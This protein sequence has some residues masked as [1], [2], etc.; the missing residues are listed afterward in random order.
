[1]TKSQDNLVWQ[2]AKQEKV[3]YEYLRN[4]VESKPPQEMIGEFR[5]LFLELRHNNTEVRQTLENIV[6]SK[7]KEYM[8]LQILNYCCHILINYWSQKAETYPY[9]WELLELFNPVNF[10]QTK[11][12]RYHD[13]R[14]Q[15]LFDLV[16]N[17][18]QTEY[19]LK[20]IRIAKFVNTSSAIKLKEQSFIGD[21]LSHYPYLYSPVLLGKESIPGTSNLILNLQQKRQ[22][23]FELQLAQH[24]IYRSRLVQIARAKQLSNRAGKI[25]KRVDNP[26]FLGEADL[27]KT[28]KQYL[29]K[30][31]ETGTIYQH[32]KRFLIEIKFI[33]S[34]KEF[35]QSLYQYLI[36]GIRQSTTN[37]YLL[38]QKLKQVIDDIYYQ[39]DSQPCTNSLMLQTYQRLLRF[40]VVDT[41]RQNDHHQL[42]ELIMNLGTTQTTALLLKIILIS[43]HVKLDLEQRLGILFSSYESH[44]I[45]DGK[46]LVKLLENILIAF[47]LYFGDINLSIPKVI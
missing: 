41:T 42:I 43:P 39:S 6:L 12:V 44:T 23:K 1:M 19:Y 45:E 26:T 33:K 18:N 34:Y 11:R 3:I 13:R 24:M 21:L 35:K 32:A 4:S 29:N 5:Y 14:R 30:I 31:D 22:K 8:F 38:Q 20:L 2:Q 27:K 17:F 36:L 9:I 37:K 7:H 28:L 10:R 46:W 25:I 47:S 40:F 16:Q 15:K